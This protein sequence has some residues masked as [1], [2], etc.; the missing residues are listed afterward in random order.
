MHMKM[1]IFTVAA[2]C[3]PLL[4]SYNASAETYYFNRGQMSESLVKNYAS[5]E[6]YNEEF[7][8]YEPA[9]GP[10]PI[11][12]IGGAETVLRRKDTLSSL[13]QGSMAGID[14]SNV[15]V[16]SI[17]YEVNTDLGGASAQGWQFYT[18]VN[19]GTCDMSVGNVLVDAD[20]EYGYNLSI[21]KRQADANFNLI[22]REGAAAKSGELNLGTTGSGEFLTS[23]TFGADAN[24]VAID[25]NGS[26]A[27][28]TDPSVNIISNEIYGLSAEFS[29]S[30]SINI[31]KGT[32]SFKRGVQGTSPSS[33][34][35][36]NADLSG[37]VLNM[38]LA[39]RFYYG[40]GTS[41]SSVMDGWIRLGDVVVS[42]TVTD[43]W[44]V[45][46]NNDRAQMNFNTT[47]TEGYAPGTAPVTVGTITLDSGDPENDLSRLDF[48]SNANAY[49]EKL[50]SANIGGSNAWQGVS[51]N[52]S[53]N[54]TITVGSMDI[55]LRRMSVNT[56][57]V[58]END[59][60]NFYYDR[61]D[62][63]SIVSAVAIVSYGSLTVK[64]NLIMR[65]NGSIC[66][67]AERPADTSVTVTVGGISGGDGNSANRIT[68]SYSM[69][70]NV[71][72]VLAINGDFNAEFSGRLHDFGQMTDLSDTEGRNYLS[73]LKEGSGVQ[74][75]R[76]DNYY[77]GTTTV[78][79]GTLYMRADG[80][81][82][83]DGY[84][85][86]KVILNGGKFGAIGASGNI[87]EVR[88]T[89]LT[90]SNNSTIAVDFSS[91]GTCDLISLSGNFL[92]AEG[93]AS[94]LYTFEFN[95][96]FAEGS[97]EYLIISWGADATVDFS[98]GDFAYEYNGSSDLTNGSFEIRDNGL[99]F[100]AV[101]EPA[102]YAALFGAL[103]LGFALLRRR[104]K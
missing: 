91:D 53:T 85:I 1:R 93:D 36:Q 66:F 73:I 31:T 26:D 46:G 45:A 37:T 103:A 14:S 97:N 95:G 75:L 21:R 81:T 51:F 67:D 65:D 101:P 84:G 89:D 79:S 55:A 25:I 80:A 92:K 58:V 83:T 68:T 63:H 23:L 57:V 41:E 20:I 40:T 60:V 48:S 64:G 33:L 7:G 32:L 5:W 22:L 15:Y 76:G 24:G 35:A 102:E 104:R 47:A 50:V 10:I 99:Y 42:G 71:E 74:I 6:T 12:E 18:S 78:N 54:S 17:I 69:L 77:R 62:A 49:I 87:G 96:N 86:G 90:W 30:K 82:R 3:V 59:L 39:S 11:D 56:H 9:T 61:S 88:A 98:E 13:Q 28:N 34:S 4:I 16:K 29:D 94:G 38:G 72:T 70:N 2:L 19:G 8:V 52:S 44:G 100:V 27:Q 43:T